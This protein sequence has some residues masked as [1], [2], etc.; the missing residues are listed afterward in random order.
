MRKIE[1][2]HDIM[3]P[4]WGYIKEGTRYKVERF[5][6][7]HVYV[8]MVSGAILRLARKRDCNIIY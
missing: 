7:R 4:G 6:K 5:N 1:I 8:K 3:I 2:K